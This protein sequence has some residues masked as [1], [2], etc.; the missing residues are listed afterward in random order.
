MAGARFFCVTTLLF[1]FALLPAVGETAQPQPLPDAP[2]PVTLLSIPQQTPPRDAH[3]NAAPAPPQQQSGPVPVHRSDTESYRVSK[4]YG[5]IDPGVSVPPL[6]THDKLMFWAHETVTPTGWFPIAF[7]AGWGQL[8]NDD[9]KYG[10]DSAAF[11]E[12][13]GAAALR[14]TSFRFFSDSLMPAITHEDPRYFRKAY[15]SIWVRGFYA[16]SQVVVTRRD[17]GEITPDYSSIV[18]HLG[19]SAL[20]MT[21]YPAVSSNARVVFQTFGWAMLGEAGGN[22]FLE[23]WPD[24]RDAVFHRHR[25]APAVITHPNP[26]NQKRK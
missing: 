20:T 6:T 18:G 7:S 25:R 12:R 19:G 8:T 13:L 23:F 10:T 17:T 24:V 16:A 15:G 4:W 2:T 1:S 9:P 11:G 5:V 26:N 14:V 22:V 21:Y 3:W